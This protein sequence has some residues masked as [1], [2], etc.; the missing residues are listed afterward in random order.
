MLH[1]DKKGRQWTG[2]VDLRDQALVALGKELQAR[3]YRFTTI[4][5]ASHSRV[6]NRPSG[7]AP[8]LERVF[9]WSQP[10]RAIELPQDIVAL[11]EQAGEVE[12]DQ[13]VLRSKVR[14]SSLGEQLFVHS[15]FP[16][17][18]PDSVFFGPDTY[19]FARALRHAIAGMPAATSF[20]I[21]DVGCGSGA[22]GLH[23][24][25][26]LRDR[27]LTDVILADINPKALRYTRINASL[28]GIADVRTVLSDLFERVNHGANLIISNPPYLLDRSGRL[29]RHGGGEFGCELSLRIVDQGID[30]L[31][32]GGRLFLYT[33]TPVV[34]G[35]D[36]FFEALRP[37]L[38]ARSCDYSYEEIDPDV[39]GEE[40]ELPPYD[41]VDR[42]AV[43]ALT[44][45]APRE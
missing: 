27:G 2:E 12:A 32:P 40:L 23:A 4:T 10:F 28:N 30:R 9:G 29:Y 26:L 24:V 39:F 13:D 3:N 8:V 35:T 44:V 36:T 11:L 33:G 37:R 6:N 19:R 17:E 16:T 22:G 20:A 25:L 41:R 18:A 45:R 34:D 1:A 31:Y 43:V 14:F 42:I 5:P 38:E 21:I 15:A 7:T